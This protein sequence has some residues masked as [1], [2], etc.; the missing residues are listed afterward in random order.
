MRAGGYRPSFSSLPAIMTCKYVLPWGSLGSIDV[1][2][3]EIDTQPSLR[4]IWLAWLKIKSCVLL[5]PE[6]YARPEWMLRFENRRLSTSIVKMS[7]GRFFFILN[8]SI[9]VKKANP[10][11][12]SYF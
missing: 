7:Q 6:V 8:Q 12:F 2:K 3:S 9:Y 1:K 10:V 11:F 4:N 5:V